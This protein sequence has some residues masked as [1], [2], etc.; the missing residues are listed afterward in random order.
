[1]LAFVFCPIAMLAE[2]QKSTTADVFFPLVSLGVTDEMTGVAAAT[3]AIVSSKTE[4]VD[5][6]TSG[7]VCLTDLRRIAGIWRADDPFNSDLASTL[8]D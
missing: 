5:I 6:V 2:R 1:M 4:P 3:A 7:L 8:R